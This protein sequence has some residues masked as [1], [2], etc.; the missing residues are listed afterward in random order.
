MCFTISHLQKYIGK[1]REGI[2]EEKERVL[3]KLWCGYSLNVP[4]SVNYN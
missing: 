4:H 3:Y 2:Q 1:E